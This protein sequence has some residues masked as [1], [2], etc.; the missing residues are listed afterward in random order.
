MRPTGEQPWPVPSIYLLGPQRVCEVELL[1]PELD[2]LL[3]S[4]NVEEPRRVAQARPQLHLRI[5]VLKRSAP[6]RP[7]ARVAIAREEVAVSLLAPAEV[8]VVA[9]DMH[10]PFVVTVFRN[11]FVAVSKERRMRKAIVF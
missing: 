4:E 11:Q 6:R 10:D 5:I 7:A 8:P 2:S 1:L 3:V 9:R